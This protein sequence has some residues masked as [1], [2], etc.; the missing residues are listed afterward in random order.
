MPVVLAGLGGGAA[1]VPRK[2]KPRSES[3]VLVAFGGA[4][5]PFGGTCVAVGPAVLDRCGM[6]SPPIRSA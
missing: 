4:G 3:L 6:G 1:S 2:S 5:L